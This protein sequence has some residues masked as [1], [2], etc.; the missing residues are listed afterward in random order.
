MRSL[1]RLTLTTPALPPF[2]VWAVRTVEHLAALRL[3]HDALTCVADA[4]RLGGVSAVPDSALLSLGSA[5]DAVVTSGAGGGTPCAVSPDEAQ[6]LHLRAD[7]A[8]RLLG[9]LRA[10]TRCARH[11]RDAW[12]DRVAST[13]GE[14]MGPTP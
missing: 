1:A 7:L 5:L 6:R 8:K 3:A 10:L 13:L 11:E 2:D 12:A 9:Q 14:A 4:I